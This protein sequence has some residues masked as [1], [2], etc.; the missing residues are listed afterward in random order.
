[1]KAPQKLVLATRRSALAL[2]QARAYAKSVQEAT[3]GL[4]IEELHVVTTGDKILDVSLSKIGGKGV[5]IKEVEDALLDQRADFA[6]HSFKDVP[7]EISDAFT[8]AC[9]PQRADA[10]DVLVSRTSH[11]LADLP[12]GAKVGTSSLRRRLE[13]LASRPD[14]DLVDIRGNVDTRLRKMD[15]GEY[16]AIV[17]AQAGLDRLG[18]SARITESLDASLCIPAAGQGALA[19]QCRAE[20]E[21]TRA[22]LAKLHHPETAIAVACER[23]IMAAVGGG[24]TV[25]FGAYAVREGE[26]L[27]L[28]ALLA[29]AD[30]ANL[31]K[32]ER[33]FPWPRGEGEAREI[34]IS[35][36][37][38][39]RER[40]G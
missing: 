34:G 9:I 29:R 13:I 38:E 10:R 40:V 6:V 11:K 17:L 5:F 21:T 26:E 27:H 32:I 3:P 4:E 14:L 31:V 23:G 36:G 22:L 20:D 18:L 35:I 19:I 33:R 1:M 12:Q 7:A 25:P 16:D 15:E 2:A 39:M 30:G 37:E 28:R 24:C 8:I